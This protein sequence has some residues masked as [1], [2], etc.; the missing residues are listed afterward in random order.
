MSQHSI[1]HSYE[2]VL[3]YF[4]NKINMLK[5]RGQIA[6]SFSYFIALILLVGVVLIYGMPSFEIGKPSDLV[7][8]LVI[9]STTMIALQNFLK[10]FGSVSAESKFRNLYESIIV[11]KAK[12]RNG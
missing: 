7:P 10:L 6:D 11:I 9:F 12:I 8:I 3:L 2:I 1:S 5:V 4:E